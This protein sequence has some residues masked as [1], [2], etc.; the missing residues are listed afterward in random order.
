MNNRYDRKYYV[1]AS[2]WQSIIEVLMINFAA[3]SFGYR[4]M[5]RNH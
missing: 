3:K 2:K 5:S 4:H 1:R